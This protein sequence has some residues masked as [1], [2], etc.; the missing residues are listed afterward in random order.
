MSQLK[1]L[2]KVNFIN[3]SSSLEVIQEK[4]IDT[5][6]LPQVEKQITIFI[7]KKSAIDEKLKWWRS[8]S[9]EEKK[10]EKNKSLV[11]T[12]TIGTAVTLLGGLIG[13]MVLEKIRNSNYEVMAIKDY[14]LHLNKLSKICEANLELLE[15]RKK[16]LNSAKHESSILLSNLDNVKIV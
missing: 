7:G 16:E 8:L 3:E 1:N 15:K 6:K 2:D 10:K 11:K 4:H 13:L 5:M 14:E 12:F 9:D